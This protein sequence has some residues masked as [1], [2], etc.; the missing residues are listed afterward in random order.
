[1]KKGI[2]KCFGRSGGGL[3]TGDV[4]TT[5]LLAIFTSSLQLG[6]NFAT[7]YFIKG[8]PGYNHVS[9]PLLALLF[10]ARP[11]LS[12]LACLLS[13]FPDTLL[14]RWFHLEEHEDLVRGQMQ[15]AKVA[16]SAA[17][18][19]IVMQLL[20]SYFLGRTANVAVNRQF[21]LIHH[22]RPYWRGK[23]ARLMYLGALFW[24]IAC[25]VMVFF[26]SVVVIFHVAIFR[27]FARTKV[28]LKQN[29]AS[30]GRAENRP[31][32]RS[33][34]FRNGAGERTVSHKPSYELTD[35]DDYQNG[36]QIHRP[37][38]F[39]RDGQR[40]NSVPAE[41]QNMRADQHGQFSSLH[42]HSE[43]S[44]LNSQTM[45]PEDFNRD[46]GAR[47]EPN[48]ST[49]TEFDSQ[50]M[51]PE[52]FQQR[53][54]RIRP[55]ARNGYGSLPTEPEVIQMRPS[56]VVRNRAHNTPVSTTA[57]EGRGYVY[58][59]LPT[60]G[61]QEEHHTPVNRPRSRVMGQ[62]YEATRHAS[63]DGG[64]GEDLNQ[65]EED[66]NHAHRYDIRQHVPSFR[67]SQPWIL[68]LGT[69]LGLV[70]YVA[71]WLFWAGFVRAYGPRFCP[72]SLASMGTLWVIASFFD[73]RIAC[74]NA[75]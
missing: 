7:A 75:K 36:G 53:D 17:M 69:A 28:W 37:E 73:L 62:G 64:R 46:D 61:N 24:L 14:M 10:C 42:T 74:P 65:P 68:A 66:S 23:D 60:D 9:A 29:A 5:I 39:R 48:R 33:W 22:L 21:Y 59:S 51:R 44:G 41:D 47:Y 56:V 11:R 45:R 52:D 34:G 6:I 50:N 49:S 16:V 38:A 72:P 67:D 25:A 40:Y 54:D 20:G 71:Q 30:S 31:R 4:V 58:S 18:S 13:S 63:Y 70:C 35:I 2:A 1:M 8:K 3:G 12:W 19:E 43:S 15:V 55:A 26:W 27:F 57:R 32:W